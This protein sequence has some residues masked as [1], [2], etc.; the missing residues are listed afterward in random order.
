MIEYAKAIG[1]SEEILDWCHTVLSSRERKIG[2]LN[3]TEVE[4]ILD[5]LVSEAAPKRL[6]RMSYQQAL[7]GADKWSKANQKRGRHLVDGPQDLQILHEFANGHK[8]VKLLTKSAYQREGFF[9]AHCVGG[10]DPATSTIYS[11]RDEEN[12]PHATFEVSQSG[13]E[14]LQIKGKGNG[15]IHPRYIEPILIF[16]RIIGQ[17]V[18]KEEMRNLGYYWVSD[19]VARLLERFVDVHGRGPQYVMLE[20][21]RYVVA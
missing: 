12:I 21:T 2:Q 6:R 20:G 11:Y 17:P 4:H 8:I 19:G 14:I 3:Q 15:P 16:L 13:D 18:R 9:Q 1:A 5:Y 7:K 10:Y